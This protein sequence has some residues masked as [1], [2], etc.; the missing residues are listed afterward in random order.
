MR[1]FCFARRAAAGTHAAALSSDTGGAASGPRAQPTPNAPCAAAADNTTDACLAYDPAA[2]AWSG[3]IAPMPLGVNHAAAGTDGE[4]MFVAGG[5]G[6][7]NR[8]GPG[9]DLL[10]VRR[11]RRRQ[12]APA[13]Q[14]TFFYCWMAAG[15]Y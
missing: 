7:P 3:G 6:G 5:R 8:V 1:S 11:R 13:R 4:R 15:A 10:Q 12:P 2:D 9:Y 14:G